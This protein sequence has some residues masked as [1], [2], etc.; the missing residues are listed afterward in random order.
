VVDGNFSAEHMKMQH[1]ENDVFLSNG[2]GYMVEWGPY[3]EHLNESV[4]TKEVCH[5]PLLDT[6][7]E[8]SLESQL[9]Q[10]Q[11]Y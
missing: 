4:V 2:L 7:S 11:G 6:L 8:D 9:C 5:P 10:S 3:E 1:P